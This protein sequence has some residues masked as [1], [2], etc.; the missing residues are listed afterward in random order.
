MPADYTINCLLQ[1]NPNAITVTVAP[2]RQNVQKRGNVQVEWHAN[3]DAVFPAENFFVW[4]PNSGPGFNPT[5]SLDGTKL[6]I[7]YDLQTPSDWSY[8]ISMAAGDAEVTVDPDIHNDPP[9][10][11]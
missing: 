1:K 11:M 9:P 5:R 3:G 6:T 8:T 7:T 4:K 10:G 2:F